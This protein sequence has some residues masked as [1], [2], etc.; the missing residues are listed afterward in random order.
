M[1]IQIPKNNTLYIATVIALAKVYNDFNYSADD[2]LQREQKRL[3]NNSKNSL[4]TFLK[5]YENPKTKE[6]KEFIKLIEDLKDDLVELI[7]ENVEY[8]EHGE[9]A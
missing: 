5:R 8:L 4:N 9:K 7:C 2:I 6:E 1:K 3:F